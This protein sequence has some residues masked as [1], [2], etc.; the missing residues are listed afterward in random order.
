MCR[1]L[2]MELDEEQLTA[3][4][5]DLDLNKDGVVDLNEF[6]RWYFTGMKPYNG[7]RRA[8]LKM[9]GKATAL[10]DAVAEETKNVL[11]E[12]ELKTISSNLVFGFNAPKNP[13]TIINAHIEFGG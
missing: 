4:L 7:T 11:M 5:I 6:K 2:G 1:V 9:G 8:L 13:K 3:A 12:E 10:M